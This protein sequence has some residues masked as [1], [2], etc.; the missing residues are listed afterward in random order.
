MIGGLPEVVLSFKQGRDYIKLLSN[1]FAFYKRD[2]VDKVKIDSLSSI[3]NQ[4]FLRIA[5]ATGAPIKNSSIIKSSS[6][7]YRKVADVLSLLENWHQ[8]IKIE[9]ETSKLTKIGTVTPKRYIFDHGIRFFQN[10]SRFNDLNLLNLL[11]PRREELGGILENFVLTELLTLNNPLPIRSWS[12]TYQ[13]GHI[14]FLYQTKETLFAIE[15]KA[16]T[17]FNKKHLSSLKSFKQIFFDSK[18]ILINLD[19]GTKCNLTGNIEVLNIPA[20]AVYSFL[21]NK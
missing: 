14:D 19:K 12:K 8:I 9:C 15:V 1:I 18:L 20:Y 5:A 6:A 17:S 10:P 11:P 2:F 7:G 4:T 3:F 21:V 13:S 16:A